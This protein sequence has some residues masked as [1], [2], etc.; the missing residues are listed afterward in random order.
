MRTQKKQPIIEEP[1]APVRTYNMMTA[2]GKR[3]RNKI[4]KQIKNVDKKEN[5]KK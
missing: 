1:K 5:K 2:K 3:Q 4:R